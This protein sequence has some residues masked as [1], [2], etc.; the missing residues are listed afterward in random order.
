VVSFK[1]RPF[2]P[3][4]RAPRTHWIEGWVDPTA[5]LDDMEEKKLLTLPGLE[6]DPSVVQ[7][8]AGQYID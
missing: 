1:L 6:M 8:V 3:G 4:K 7:P 2:Y 5:G